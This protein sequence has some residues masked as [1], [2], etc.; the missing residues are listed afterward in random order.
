MA[1]NEDLVLDLNRKF[2]LVMERLGIGSGEE[3]V[4]FTS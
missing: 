4:E 2:D 3:H 1:R